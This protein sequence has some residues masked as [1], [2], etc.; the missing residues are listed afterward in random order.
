MSRYAKT[1]LSW[2]WLSAIV[3]LLDQASKWLVL[4]TMTEYQSL[5]FIPFINFT[6]M[7][8]HGAAFSFLSQ[9]G[10]WQ[11]WL[12][13]AI[14]VVI[15][16]FLVAWLR[17]THKRDKLVGIGLALI[18]GGAIGNLI[19]RIYHGYVVDFIDFH[20]GD[21]HWFTFNIA[22]V[23]ISFGV[24]ALFLD[25]FVN[26]SKS[27]KNTDTEEVIQGHT[28]EFAEDDDVYRH[29]RIA[30]PIRAD[31]FRGS[32]SE[33]RDLKAAQQNLANQGH[34]K[35][36]IKTP[37]VQDEF[38]SENTVAKASNLSEGPQQHAEAH[39]VTGKSARFHN[40][41]ENTAPLP[42]SPRGEKELQN[43]YTPSPGNQPGAAPD[44]KVAPD[45][46][47]PGM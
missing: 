17:R 13:T 11:R 22:D 5:P 28:R 44:R 37:N 36:G 23:A 7:F 6:L 43:R 26:K 40:S 29:E 2:I 9:R 35:L 31:D 25:L 15:C 14:A 33:A 38:V 18:L 4:A 30:Q 21:W 12:F 24:T 42:D 41:D 46:K 3:I 20:L 34:Q 8:N 16:A 45:F 1:A 32:S 47:P 27:P 10:G 39:P 19:D